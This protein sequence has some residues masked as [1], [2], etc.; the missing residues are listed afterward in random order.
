LSA[1][2]VA[3]AVG[4]SFLFDRH[5]RVVTPALQ[6]LRRRG[7]TTWGLR[8]LDLR[9][10]AGDAV[11]LLGGSG[12]G[13]TTL[14]RLLAGVLSPDAGELALRGR[15]AALLSVDA[16]LLWHL[17]GRENARLLGVLAGASRARTVAALDEIKERSMLDE[18]FEQPVSTYSQGMRARLALAATD[19]A[20]PTVLLL[21]EVHEALDH[22]YRALLDQRARKL[23]ESGGIVVASGH[24][25]ELLRQLCDRALL[26]EDGRLV[27]DGEFDEVREVYLSGLHTR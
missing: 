7:V 10:H 23:R 12:A 14:L 24:D 4:V 11:A 13:K 22:Q 3:H 27:R 2:L 21:D 26:L 5:N 15:V 16:G 20:E 17:T 9:L 18:H 6:R 8:A 1:S 19:V 25:H